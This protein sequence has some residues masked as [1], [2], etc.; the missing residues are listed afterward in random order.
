MTYQE[1][2][3]PAVLTQP[4]YEPGRPIDAVAR[5]YGLELG[6]VLKLASNENPLG[7]SPMALE[8]VQ[9][10]LGD[11]HLYPDGGCTQLLECLGQQRG[12]AADGIIVGNGSNEIMVLLAQAFL[13]PGDEVVFGAQAFIVYKLAT[14][15]C[16]ATPIEV[17]M[18]D[19]KH[20]LDALIDAITDRTKIVFL[21]SPNNPTGTA[22]TV[23]EMVGFVER[24]PEHVIFCFDEAYAEY[25]QDAPDLR[26]FI[27]QGKK[28]FCTRT[29]SKIYGL[30][31][32]RIGYGYG[33]PE[34]VKL[35]HRVRQPF[36][37][38]AL[39]QAAAL[40]ALQDSTFVTESRRVNLHGLAQLRQGLEELGLSTY[41]S[42][43]NFLLLRVEDVLQV[44]ER[45]QAQGVITRPLHAYAMRH[46]IRIS[47]GTESQNAKFLEV[48]G[49]LV[50]GPH[51]A[52]VVKEG[53]LR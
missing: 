28:V 41:P 15:L 19:F 23:A 34:V 12:L 43:A 11:S 39:A 36:N 3:C 45:L 17:P 18:P 21:P 20:D 30:A 24:L 8:A 1:L 9:R 27:E 38:N 37:V 10:T 4:V 13:Q 48:F 42:A 52:C 6:E 32:F 50:R 14:L 44:V 29:F 51:R 40:G 22:N 33:A 16:G 35:L 26:P 49:A 5:E 53:S 31:G 25:L 2:V 7:P 47:V 46:H